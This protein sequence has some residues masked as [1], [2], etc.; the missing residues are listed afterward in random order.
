M[1][2]KQWAKQKRTENKTVWDVYVKKGKRLSSDREQH[3]QYRK[4]LGKHISK[5][6]DDFQNLKY[7]EPEKWALLKLD[8]RR[9]EELAAHPEKAL[10]GE[11]HVIPSAKSTGYL[12]NP[13]SPKGWAKGQ[14][15]TSHLGYS[16]ENWQDLKRELSKGSQSYPSTLKGSN[17]YGD[18]YEQKMVLYG[19]T[20]NPANVI[21]GWILK[22][23]GETHMT[24]THFKEVKP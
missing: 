1:T 17:G 12:F 3:A 7:N 19:V 22:P 23:N 10:P 16:A 9:R 11:R 14:A 18:L 4:I 5:E 20:N 2:Y 21:V 15:F 8:K 13:D 24:T 6:L